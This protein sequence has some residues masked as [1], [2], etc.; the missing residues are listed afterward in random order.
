LLLII[1]IQWIVFKILKL[2][3]MVMQSELEEVYTFIGAANGRD[4]LAMDIAVLNSFEQ[5][6]AHAARL[7]RQHRSLDLIEV[8]RGSVL[9]DLIQR[10]DRELAR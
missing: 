9:V 2:M 8:W 3:Q 5:A 7:L 1:L 6:R 4:A 10:A